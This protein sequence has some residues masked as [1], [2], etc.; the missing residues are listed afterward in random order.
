M[1]EFNDNYVENIDD[2]PIAMPMS[3]GSVSLLSARI[4]KKASGAVLS[5]LN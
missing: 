1:Q 2:F 3:R 5:F 4:W